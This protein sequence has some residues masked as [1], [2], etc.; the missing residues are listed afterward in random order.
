VAGTRSAGSESQRLTSGRTPTG[1]SKSSSSVMEQSSTA[2]SLRPT[3]TIGA[4]TWLTGDCR[5]VLLVRSG[6]LGTLRSGEQPQQ[7]GN[8]EA[9]HRLA[10]G[11]R[12]RRR[13][14]FPRRGTRAAVPR[15]P[16][17][18]GEGLLLR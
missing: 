4:L 3:Q 16:L 5:P 11:V 1:G 13:G 12:R 8:H 17:R 18:R 7:K 6:G 2:R 9:I 10:R 14:G 15:L